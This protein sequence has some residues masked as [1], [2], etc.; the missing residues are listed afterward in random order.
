M[1][2]Q[3]RLTESNIREGMNLVRQALLE[4]DA[5]V[6]T[7]R[8]FVDSVQEKVLGLEVSRALNPTQQILK[9]VPL[10]GSRRN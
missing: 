8:Q 5:N 10:M 6:E 9:I 7:T 1:T 4:A 2:G 3:G